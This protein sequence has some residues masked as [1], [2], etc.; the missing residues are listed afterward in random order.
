MD[1]LLSQEEINALFNSTDDDSTEETTATAAASTAAASGESL[2]GEEKDA[3][4]EISN[5]SMGSSATTL[6]ALVNQKVDISTPSVSIVNW[7]QLVGA[8]DKPCIFI[9]I[10]YKEGLDGNN[11]L[12]LK[13]NDVK[14][15][16]DLMMGG[17]GTNTSGE[18][19][20]LHLSAISEAM[21]QMMGSASTSIS[22][23]IEAKVDITP[24]N[25]TV[26][27]MT[28]VEDAGKIASFLTKDFVKV[29]FKMTV[30]DLVDSELMQLYPIEFARNLYRKFVGGD[31]PAPAAEPA[32][33]PAAPQAAAA[34]NPGM[35]GQQG[36]APNPGMMNMG[37]GMGM[38]PQQMQMPQMGFAMPPQA[39]VNVSPAQFQPFMQ[40]QSPLLQTENIDLLL[41]VPLEVSVELGRTSRTIK[42]ILDFAPGTVVELN[43]LAGEPIDVLVNGKYVAK[44]EVV[45]IG[46]SFGIRITEVIK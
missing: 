14:V 6:A 2:S 38:M 18:L 22:S 46:E 8:Y 25:A 42:E 43:R 1:G 10:L 45:V 34:P 35:M 29:S 11:I 17:D 26:I 24:P 32:P 30:G 15:I 3:I 12:I 40:V 31:Q 16:A 4:G 44:G 28:N 13:E 9:Q 33:E 27:D 23:M 36:M 5:I 37:Y 20:D 19:S 41:D 39:D 21:N 7:E